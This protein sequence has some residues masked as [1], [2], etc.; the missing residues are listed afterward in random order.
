MDSK[1]QIVEM[2]CDWWDA[3]HARSNRDKIIYTSQAMLDE[4]DK[5]FTDK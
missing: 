1:K 5:A 4:Y 2:L 3:L